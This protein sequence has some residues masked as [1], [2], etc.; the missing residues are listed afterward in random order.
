MTVRWK[1]LLVLSGLFLIIAVIGVVTIMFTLVPGGSRDILPQARAERAAKQYDRALI[2][3][4]RAL[5][6][7]GRNAAI[8]EEIAAMYG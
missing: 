2:H 8:H 1:P 6:K 7:D 5:Q 3:Y 4:K